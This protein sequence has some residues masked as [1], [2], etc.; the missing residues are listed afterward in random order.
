MKK[1]LPVISLTLFALLGCGKSPLFNHQNAPAIKEELKNTAG[2]AVKLSKENLCVNYT[3]VKKPTEEEKGSF[4]L[5]FT[6]PESGELTDPK[7]T[8]FVKLWMPSMGHGS[9]PTK[10]ARASKG[11]YDVTEVFFVMGGEWEIWIQL[12]DGNKVLEQ[13]K[14]D[15]VQ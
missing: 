7:P 1:Q 14:F 11:T 12:K 5:L 8:V 9:S 4:T 3:W 13:T 15:Y 10:T 6:N 2:C